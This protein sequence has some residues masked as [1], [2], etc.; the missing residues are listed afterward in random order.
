M[1]TDEKVAHLHLCGA[2]M[3][4]VMTAGTDERIVIRPHRFAQMLR[5][6]PHMIDYQPRVIGATALVPMYQGSEIVLSNEG[7]GL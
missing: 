4:A 6:V 1:S 3:R 2:K 7:A 5:S